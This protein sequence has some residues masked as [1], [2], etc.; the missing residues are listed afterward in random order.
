MHVKRTANFACLTD[1][2]SASLTE[3]HGSSVP[4]NLLLCRMRP[5]YYIHVYRLKYGRTMPI[6]A[7]MTRYTGT[8]NAP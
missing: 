7:P 2:N 3:F 8:V 5:H 6:S 1:G 4:P